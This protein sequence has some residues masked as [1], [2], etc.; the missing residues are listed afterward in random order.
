MIAAIT[1]ITS[2]ILGYG[3]G[4]NGEAPQREIAAGGGSPGRIQREKTGLEHPAGD[5]TDRR[6]RPVQRIPQTPQDL[7][8]AMGR[9]GTSSLSSLDFDSMFRIWRMAGDMDAGQIRDLLADLDATKGGKETLMAKAILANQF[10]EKEGV[11]ALEYF[12]TLD[13][14]HERNAGFSGAM[15]GWMR[16]N[17]DEAYAWL[18]QNQEKLDQGIDRG[19]LTAFYFSIKSR[20]DYSGALREASALDPSGKN[21]AF[22]QL[23]EQGAADPSQREALL[24]FLKGR[25]DEALVKIVEREM[26]DHLAIKD[27][28]EAMNVIAGLGLDDARRA[29]LEKDSL[30]QWSGSDPQAAIL[31]Q[32][33]R[34]AGQERAGDQ[35]A[36]SFRNWVGKDEA[37]ASD[38]L[39]AQGPEFQ[40]DLVFQRAG[41]VLQHQ[42]PARA[43]QWQSQ[44]RDDAARQKAYR[45][46]YNR[47][48]M[49]DP[50]AADAWRASLPSAD[51][52]ALTER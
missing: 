41:E 49:K 28:V 13:D 6:I 14:P 45:K 48:R 24:G 10:G 18:R 17:P 36:D 47:W 20:E 21:A 52:S 40:T 30:N 35:I 31:W 46:L 42:N 5:R 4:K 38:W 26:I 27:P 12:L 11:G 16:G 50:L 25:N 7:F 39:R 29:E 19:E 37:A 33:K 15:V 22:K 8:N 32:Q 2:G 23:A 3:L 51:H 9:L 1:A 34:L 44:V 43:A